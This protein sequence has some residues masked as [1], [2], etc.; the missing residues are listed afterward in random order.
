MNDDNAPIIDDSPRAR[1]L[2]AR[3]R[4]ECGIAEADTYLHAEWL[5]PFAA[6]YQARKLWYLTTRDAVDRAIAALE[7]EELK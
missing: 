1:L 2:A 6:A 3:W 7:K 5:A 4:C